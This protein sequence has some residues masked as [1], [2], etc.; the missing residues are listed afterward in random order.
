MT[1]LRTRLTGLLGTSALLALLVGTPAVLV[2][3]TPVFLLRAQLPSRWTPQALWSI[4]SRPD[5]GT[6]FVLLL[7]ATCW[8]AWAAMA[9]LV[10]VEA[11]ALVRGVQPPQLPGLPQ[12][13][14][15]RLVTTALLLFLATPQLPTAA[16]LALPLEQ[17]TTTQ[18][19]PQSTVG[20]TP[21]TQPVRETTTR[22]V[23]Q[24]GETLWSIAASQLGAGTR[25]AEIVALNHDLLGGRAD[26][27]RP[28]WVLHLP[29]P[30]AT[31]T[32]TGTVT[33]TVA[34]GDTLSEIA[35]DH[36]GDA[37]S[38]PAIAEAS[39]SIEQRGGRHLVDPDVIDVGWTLHLPLPDQPLAP[40]DD[41]QDPPMTVE[42]PPAPAELPAEVLPEV[43]TAPSTSAPE[44]AAVPTGVASPTAAASAPAAVPDTVASPA[45]AASTAPAST[46]PAPA[47]ASDTAAAVEGSP[48]MPAWQLAGLTGAG[49]VLASGLWVAL[50][51]HRGA[52]FRARRPGRMIAGTPAE[53]VGIEKTLLTVGRATAPT[54]A[55]MDTALRRLARQLVAL[56]RPM[57]PLHAVHLAE[58]QLVL[59]LASSVLE[60]PSPWL[61]SADGVRWQVGTDVDPDTLGELIPSWPAPYPQLVT[62]GTAAD[63]SLWLVNLEQAGVL[64]LDGPTAV[65]ADFA[66]YLVAEIAINPWSIDVGVRYAALGAGVAHLNECRVHPYDPDALADAA[67]RVLADSITAL[68]R[69]DDAAHT[70]GHSFDVATARAHL[71]GEEQWESKLLVVSSAERPEALR[72]LIGLVV[73]HPATTGTVVLDLNGPP[74]PDGWHVTL[75]TDRQLRSTLPVPDLTAVGLTAKEAEGCASLLDQR[76]L[77]DVAMPEDPDTADPQGLLVDQAGQLRDALTLPRD[78]A[79]LEPTSSLLPAPDAEYLAVAATTRA[80]LAAIAPQVPDH[81]RDALAGTDPG[82]DDDL[83]AWYADDCPLPRLSVLGPVTVRIAATGSRQA[84]QGRHPHLIDLLAYL[85][86]RTRG[87]TTAEVTQAMNSP[88]SRARKNVAILR[89][90]LGPNPRTGRPHVPDARHTQAAALRGQPAYEVEDILVDADMFRRLRARAQTRGPA[91]LA[92][93]EEALALVHG[94]PYDALREDGGTWLLEGDRLDH[95]LSAA[96]V[97]AAH[98]VAVGRLHDG[99]LDAARRAAQTA[100]LAVPSDETAQLDLAAILAAEGDLPAARKHLIDTV[101]SRS[102]DELDIPMDLPPRSQQVIDDHGWFARTKRTAG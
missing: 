90:W 7:V 93:L 62:W 6:L 36:L 77:D 11:A 91:G 76:Q 32:Q 22:H 5:D 8:V 38:Y 54:T 59:H 75:D 21:T 101:C 72:E 96:I 30:A 44:P 13:A 55:F 64:T 83:R 2:G 34:R 58:G 87:A 41:P 17:T 14:V 28:G 47:A 78:V 46:A 18:T 10:V 95:I 61:A 98:L 68:D 35:A 94:V 92:D 50:R 37:R 49:A 45:A 56:D 82:L 57:P 25:F 84:A 51:R 79:S 81:V 39:R 23:V 53:L 97:D 40:A 80:D 20:D 48:S 67:A 9:S 66:R 86:S 63:D 73:T 1:Q 102:D 27:L 60:P 71:Y 33:Y 12:Q 52:Q 15:R 29:A 70:V 26:F 3:A 19:P 88:E 74:H 65:V 85:T 89:D 42:T 4:L 16:A 31:G 43:A 69:A 100:R 24:R 99:D